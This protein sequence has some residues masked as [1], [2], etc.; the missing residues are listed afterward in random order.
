MMKIIVTSNV[1]VLPNQQNITEEVREVC[2][3]LEDKFEI[4][5]TA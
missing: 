5:I 3:N 1:N 2:D 4:K